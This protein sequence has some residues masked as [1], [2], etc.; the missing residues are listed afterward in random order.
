M[1]RAKYIS[2]GTITYKITGDPGPQGP[3]GP[4]GDTGKSA[5]QIAVDNGFNGT[6]AEWLASLNGDLANLVLKNIAISQDEL[7]SGYIGN[8]GIVH[9]HTDYSCTDFIELSGAIFGKNIDVY[10]LIRSS[11]GIAFYDSKKSLLSAIIGYNASQYDIEEGSEIRSIKIPENAKFV[12]ATISNSDSNNIS[13]EYMSVGYIGETAQKSNEFLENANIKNINTNF[14]DGYYVHLWG[15][16]IA[17]EGYTKSDFILARSGT[18][19]TIK[20]A[21]APDGCALIA[22]YDMNKIFTNYISVGDGIRT[23]K[24]VSVTISEDSYIVLSYNKA[25]TT[26]YYY[27]IYY[28]DLLNA[29]KKVNIS[30]SPLAN[31]NNDVSFIRCFDKIVCIGDS[32]TKGVNN[33]TSPTTS[34][35]SFPTKY[36]YPKYLSKITGCNTLNIGQGGA[37]ASH[38][39]DNSWESFAD[40]IGFVDAGI[41]ANEWLSE[42]NKGDLYIIAL[43]TNDIS[44]LGAFTGDV[45][46]DIDLSNYNNNASTSVGGYARII[47]R[48]IEATPKCK[49]MCVCISNSRNTVET[50]TEANNKIKAIA[51]KFD[52][53]YVIDLQTCAEVLDYEQHYFNLYYKNGSHNNS[54]G[55][56]IRAKQYAT[57]IDWIIKNNI[58]DFQNIAFIGSN[59]DYTD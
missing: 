9:N 19:I 21:C 6:E 12:R 39:H 7:I 33:T 20:N 25:Y 26:N 34:G 46:T 31:V 55:Y 10:C 47:Q 1:Q 56:Y 27:N 2:N 54:L 59:Y 41:G 4:K 44:V 49:I 51:D 3:E 40:S 37:T 28:N 17:K 22:R 29:S 15:V 43:G 30:T 42:S 32:L 18:V 36:S 23:P 57:Y 24:D 13:F 52:N 45:N 14:T 16:I 11:A 35:V 38:S 8:D 5:Y 58:Y 53:C 48:I 50:R